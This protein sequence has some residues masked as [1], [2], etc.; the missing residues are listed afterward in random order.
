[1]IDIK[2]LRKDPYFFYKN[3]LKKNFKLN[4]N[5]ISFLDKEI[6]YLKSNLQKLQLEHN[7]CTNNIQQLIINKHDICDDLY[8]KSGAMKKS[9]KNTK[10]QLRNLK[11]EWDEYYFSIPNIVDNLVP[12]N[13]N[14]IIKEK[15]I[16]KHTSLEHYNI[17]WFNKY[18][19]FDKGM[20]ISGS[21]FPCYT[22]CIAL[23]IRALINFFIEEAIMNNYEE[24]MVPFLVNKNS[25]F[26]TGQFPDKESQMYEV[27]KDNFFLIPTAEIPLTNFYQNYVFEE[28]LLPVKIFSYTPC[29][30]REAGSW[31]KNVRGL[32]RVHQFDKVELVKLVH[33]DTH[34]IELQ[35]LLFDAENIVKK[36]ELPYR[37]LLINSKDMGFSQYKQYDIEVWASGQKKWLEISSCSSFNDFQSRRANIKY[38]SKNNNKNFIHTMNGSALAVP[39]ILA[40]ILENNLC[41]NG[42][43]KIPKVLKK[44]MN[45][46]FIGENFEYK[47]N[48]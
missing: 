39:R 38:I 1:M 24:I 41:E 3:L 28:S 48:K 44:Y 43:V 46:N 23:L 9:I 18:V 33:P 27:S 4:L 37:I 42:L 8:K 16:P 29:F 12:D 32:N 26:S 19:K 7:I 15:G 2:L 6:R 25:A 20:I 40:A 5:K 13:E 10:Q 36:L 21:G 47:C 22:N 17:P 45:C 11:T 35:K 31:G 34:E 14:V 30:R